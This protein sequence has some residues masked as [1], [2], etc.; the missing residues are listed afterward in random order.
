M[1]DGTGVNQYTIMGKV[2][3]NDVSIPRLKMLADPETAIFDNYAG[4]KKA[5]GGPI[6]PDNQALSTFAGDPNKKRRR[7]FNDRMDGMPPEQK[8]NKFYPKPYRLFVGEDVYGDKIRIFAKCV[9][10]GRPHEMIDVML[11]TQSL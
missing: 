1:N 10:G 2:G 5:F 11:M 7:E 8:G 4:H 6:A 9:S 3:G